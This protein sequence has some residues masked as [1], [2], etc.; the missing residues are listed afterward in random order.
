MNRPIK[1]VV[2]SHPP[3][4]EKINICVLGNSTFWNLNKKFFDFFPNGKGCKF[5]LPDKTTRKSKECYI[6]KSLEY[7]TPLFKNS[8]NPSAPFFTSIA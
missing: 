4:F 5:F 3:F 6:K 1:A 8:Q 7:L 2:D